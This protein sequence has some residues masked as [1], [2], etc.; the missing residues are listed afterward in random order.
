MLTNLTTPCRHER[1]IPCRRDRAILCHHE[2]ATLCRH[3]EAPQ[4]RHNLPPYDRLSP[5]GDEYFN[6]KEIIDNLSQQWNQYCD[7]PRFSLTSSE[8]FE[9][10]QNP[11]PTAQNRENLRSNI[12]T[13]ADYRQSLPEMQNY[14]NNGVFLETRETH[15][16]LRLL[17]IPPRIDNLGHLSDSDDLGSADHIESPV[18]SNEALGGHR[19]SKSILKNSSKAGIG[20]NQIMSENNNV[21]FREN[22]FC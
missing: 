9:V 10:I 19:A 7:V 1:T 8:S 6:H 13:L 11:S 17:L 21:S 18:T 22:R 15:P 4:N 2:R 5:S 16:P 14:N 20:S 3:T 12:A